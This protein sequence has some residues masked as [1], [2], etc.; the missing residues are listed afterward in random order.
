MK[1]VFS[2]LTSE[3]DLAN[4]PKGFYKNSKKTIFQPI[5]G[6]EKKN[7]IFAASP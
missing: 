5:C 3:F 6:V 2:I 7:I 1:S 4:T